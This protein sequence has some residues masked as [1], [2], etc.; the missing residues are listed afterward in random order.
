MVLL[1]NPLSRPHQFCADEP[2]PSKAGVL[3]ATGRLS[4]VKSIPVQKIYI[5]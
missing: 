1:L 3:I 5:F 4:L 2:P